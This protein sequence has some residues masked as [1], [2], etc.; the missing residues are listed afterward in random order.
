MASAGLLSS[1][2]AASAA[3]VQPPM[4]DFDAAYYSCDQ[5]QGFQISYDSKSPASATVTTS[6]NNARHQLKRVSAASGP[7]FSD[8][9]VTVSVT[10]Q[11]AQV[12]GTQVALTG[13][14]LKNTV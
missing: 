2:L 3:T 6:D 14:K 5:G 11:G 7:E 4:G 12:K 13:C 1:A 8:G 10:S 9:T